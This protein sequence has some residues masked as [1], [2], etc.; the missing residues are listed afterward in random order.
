MAANIFVDMATTVEVMEGNCASLSEFFRQH[1]NKNS[2]AAIH[3][4]PAV[5]LVEDDSLKVFSSRA[6]FEFE[7]ASGEVTYTKHAKERNEIDIFN[8]CFD[9]NLRYVAETYKSNASRV[10]VG[11]TAIFMNFFGDGKDGLSETIRFLSH[12][13][14]DYDQNKQGDWRFWYR[15]SDGEWV[16]SSLCLFTNYLYNISRDNLKYKETDE[17]FI[18]WLVDRRK[19][20]IGYKFIGYMN[21]LAEHY[22]R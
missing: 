13:R 10:L 12:K 18:D 19:V 1:V 11:L 3:T 15:D 9:G 4:E 17:Y 7:A 22:E 5:V 20:H 14:F 16:R 2:Y 8:K 6:T 21:Y